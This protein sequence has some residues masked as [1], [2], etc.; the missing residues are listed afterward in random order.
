MDLSGNSE[1]I[2]IDIDADENL[3]LLVGELN[4]NI[5]YYEYDINDI[6]T[7]FFKQRQ[8]CRLSLGILIPVSN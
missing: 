3:E 7:L 6:P 4:G 1:P 8:K 5:N 2:L